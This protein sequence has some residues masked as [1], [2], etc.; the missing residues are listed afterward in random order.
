MESM[1]VS[2]CSHL[3]N[4]IQR[5]A[6]FRD[7][8]PGCALSCGRFASIVWPEILAMMTVIGECSIS[9]LLCTAFV[10]SSFG[11]AEPRTLLA[12]TANWSRN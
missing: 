10:A 2:G 3:M 5:D 4:V 1:P 7:L 6:A 8:R 12:E 9:V 11:G